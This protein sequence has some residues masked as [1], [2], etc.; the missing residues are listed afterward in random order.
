MHFKFCVFY[1]SAQCLSHLYFYNYNLLL[2][3]KKN[4]PNNLA[5]VTSHLEGGE[6]SI[7]CKSCHIVL[8]FLQHP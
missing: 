1:F 3:L 2:S 4:Y 7:A 8:S 6:I 5:H